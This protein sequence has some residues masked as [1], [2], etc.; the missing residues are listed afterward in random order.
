MTWRCWSDG[1]GGPIAKTWQLSG[2][3]LTYV[4]DQDG[5]IR[6]KYMGIINP[7]ILTETVTEMVDCLSKGK[8]AVTG[9]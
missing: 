5:V 7:G 3:P 9:E 8:P 2:Y 6:H 4:I 1:Q